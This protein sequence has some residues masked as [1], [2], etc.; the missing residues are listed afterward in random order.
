MSLFDWRAGKE[1]LTG[2]G[3]VTG[4]VTCVRMLSRNRVI[5]GGHQSGLSSQ[6]FIC[7]VSLDSSGKPIMRRD[8]PPGEAL[9]DI[10]VCDDGETYIVMSRLAF[11]L[12]DCWPFPSERAIARIELWRDGHHEVLLESSS[13]DVSNSIGPGDMMTISR[14]RI[15]C[16]CTDGMFVLE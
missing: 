3:G 9:R 10:L 15:V 14:E 1:L 6:C 7:I 12:D 13:F 16:R 4:N 5:F 8:F 2:L 11:P